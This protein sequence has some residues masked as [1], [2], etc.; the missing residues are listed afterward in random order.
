[1]LGTCTS[2]NLEARA[3][4]SQT[5]THN[6]DDVVAGPLPLTPI[7]SLGEYQGL[8]YEGLQ[9]INLSKS[10]T[11]L[12]PSS[13]PNVLQFDTLST[14]AAPGSTLNRAHITPVPRAGSFTPKSLCFGC[15]GPILETAVTLPA[16]CQL[17]ARGYSAS[18][19]RVA[20]QTFTYELKFGMVK[21]DLKT[22]QFEGVGWEGVGRV[23]LS[24][25]TVGST[26]TLACV[27]DGFVWG[28]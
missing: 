15:A 28:A 4:G 18:G 11:G 10:L 7:R 12:S 13:P 25:K 5:V 26:A 9:L 6:Y 2:A 8:K 23:E 14:L 22:V 27:V 17:I 21:Q 1:M 3:A 16:P 19:A 20:E 24:A